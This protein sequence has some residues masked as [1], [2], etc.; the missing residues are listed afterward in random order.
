MGRW[1]PNGTLEYLGRKD[2][3][4]KVKGIR[5]EINEIQKALICFP[6][7]KDAFV[8]VKENSQGLLALNAYLVTEQIVDVLSIRNFLNRTLPI[9]MLP[10]NFFCLDRLPLTVSGKVDREVLLAM[11]NKIG[12][13]K[14]YCVPENETE[15]QLVII[16]QELLGHHSIGTGDS[17]YELGGDSLKGMVLLKRISDYFEV[18]LVPADFHGNPTIRSL[19]IRLNEISWLKSDQIW[20]NEISL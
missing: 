17:F 12:T 2:D 4:V 9:Y 19:A 5:I 16:W 11:D 6:G 20:N 3:Q 14:P 8:A 7:I 1:L 18:S 15:R 10:E 13:T